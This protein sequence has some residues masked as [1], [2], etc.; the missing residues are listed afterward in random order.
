MKTG[1][2]TVICIQKDLNK[3]LLEHWS[4]CEYL[5]VST[6]AFLPLAILNLIN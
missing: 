2:G 6:L 4:E 1:K 5:K 3:V